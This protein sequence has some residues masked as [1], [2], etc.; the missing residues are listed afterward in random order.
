MHT[1]DDCYPELKDWVAEGINRTSHKGMFSQVYTWNQYF[2][3]GSEGMGM[4]I[5]Q[6]NHEAT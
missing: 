6:A 2:Y 1:A 3:H 5:D 4:H